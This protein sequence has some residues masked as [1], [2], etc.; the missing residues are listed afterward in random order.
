MK[1]YHKIYNLF[2]RDL[3]VKPSKLVEGDFLKPEFELLKDISWH[4][5]EKID[6]MNVRVMFDGEQVTF[7]GKTDRAQIPPKLLKSLE[8]KF[9]SGVLSQVFDGPVCLYGEGYGMKIQDGSKYIP[10]DQDFILFDVL[11]NDKW[12]ERSNVVDIANSLQIDVA[13]TCGEGTLQEAVEFVKKGFLSDWGNFQAEGIIC[14]PCVEL[15]N[16]Q[17]NR[18]ITKIKHVDFK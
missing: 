6:G 1:E 9:Y 3:S 11:I 5:S 10:E 12:L 13:P 7:A 2:K 16:G 17:G 18:I 15:K 14:R 8:S 4:W